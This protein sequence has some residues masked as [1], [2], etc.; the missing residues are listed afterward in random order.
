MYKYFNIHI[1]GNPN[2]QSLD[3]AHLNSVTSNSAQHV[4][5]PA[6]TVHI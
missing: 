3:I 5:T 6:H 1:Q 4:Y 2:P